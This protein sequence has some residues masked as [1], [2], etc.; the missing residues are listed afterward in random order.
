LKY[1][2]Q[3]C[4][5][6]KLLGGRNI[7]QGH[8][9]ALGAGGRLHR[10]SQVPPAHCSAVAPEADTPMF[11]PYSTAYRGAVILFLRGSDPARLI[12]P[13]G[14][15]AQSPHSRTPLSSLLPCYKPAAPTG[16][17]LCTMTPMHLPWTRLTGTMN[18]FWPTYPDPVPAI[19]EAMS[20]AFADMIAPLG[21]ALGK[22]LVELRNK[23]VVC[24]LTMSCMRPGDG[25][26]ARSTACNPLFN[27]DIQKGLTQF[28][29][30]STLVTNSSKKLPGTQG[31]LDALRQIPGPQ[32]RH[33]PPTGPLHGPHGPHLHPA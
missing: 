7:L 6:F 21:S 11:Q 8:R 4:R 3:N 25:A 15:L 24:T 13:A 32:T 9:P 10:R 29:D 28:R 23:S 33:Q 12:L 30:C 5:V 17:S 26:L 22:N 1:C 20:Q 18:P 19:I 16:G 31:P 14:H 2:V 27:S